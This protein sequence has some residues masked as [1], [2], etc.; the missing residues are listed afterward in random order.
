M[1]ISAINKLLN[2]LLMGLLMTKLW[3]FT[4]PATFTPLIFGTQILKTQITILF[5][6][7]ISQVYK[8]QVFPVEKP[9]ILCKKVIILQP[10]T[11]QCSKSVITL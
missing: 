5:F 8:R 10:K 6:F 3:D 9:E 2:L 11:M 7:V 4:Y 1:K